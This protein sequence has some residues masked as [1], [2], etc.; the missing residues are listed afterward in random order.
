[1]RDIVSPLMGLRSPFGGRVDQYKAGGF[2][3]TLVADMTRDYY[4]STS[5]QTFDDLFTHSRLGNATMVDSD[6]LLKWGPHNLQDYSEDLASTSASVSNVTISSNV[7]TAPDGS[8]TADKLVSYN[9]TGVTQWIRF[10]RLGPSDVDSV[11]RIAAKADGFRYITIGYSNTGSYNAEYDLQNGVVSASPAV[12]NSTASITEIGDGW[13]W[14]EYAYNHA[15]SIMFISTYGSSSGVALGGA[16]TSIVGD[17][18][19]GVL[20]WGNHQYRSD[21]GGMAPVPPDARVAGS[22]TYVPTTSAAVYLPRRGHHVWDGSAWVNEG[23]LHESEARTNLV[24]Y[25][26]DISDIV[27]S[28]TGLTTETTDAN[29]YTPLVETATSLGHYMLQDSAL[30]AGLAY[31]LSF[32]VRARENTLVQIATSSG[33]STSY[34]NFDLSSGSIGSSSVSGTITQIGPDEYRVSATDI[35]VGSSGRMVIALINSDA[36]GRLPNYTGTS[37]NGILIRRIQFEQGSTPSSYIPTSGSTAT[38][39]AETLTVP[40]ANL[41]W[42]TPRVIGDEL[43]TNGTFDTGVSGWTADAD[44]SIAW[45]A[46]TLK[47]TGAA[48]GPTYM[49]ASQ[50]ITTVAGRVYRLSFEVTALSP[51]NEIRC[52]VTGTSSVASV[53]GT[54][55][56]VGY[57]TATQV[58]TLVQFGIVG[59][60]AGE[61]FNIDNISVREIDPLAV[62]I[63][64][65]GRMTYADTDVAIEVQW[66]EWEADTNNRII[67]Y[68]QT[69]SSIT[70]QPNFQQKQSG[71]ADTISASDTYSPGVLVP[72]N[73]ASRH[74]S[75][76]INGAVDGTALTADTTPVA[77]PD[78]SAT[79]LSLGYDFMGTIK[80]LRI[81]A[82]DIGDTGIAEASS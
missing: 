30:T 53:L 17:G 45:D 75:T 2:R 26:D 61:T 71:T 44:G 57:F 24:T 47:Y 68:L 37:G 22:T 20:L 11:W 66:V 8:A 27:W 7:A 76:F 43:V 59:G 82:D 79:D 39:A 60:L 52:N 63:Q 34:I 9:G 77:L 69:V 12:G 50:T 73:I 6:G 62:S 49:D 42:P 35:A 21:L 80:T 14:L 33:F 58:S 19:S 36:T 74:G 25:S 48:A 67:G 55:V 54:G 18:S 4:R 13:Y 15:G 40:N 81:W 5:R 41:P 23:L 78:L 38:R 51:T 31:T 56:A 28:K 65:E 72:F 29:G 3:P 46:G 32:D 64:M 10:L 1:M 16:D 70:G